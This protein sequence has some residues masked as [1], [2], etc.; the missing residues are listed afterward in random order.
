MT[1]RE[2][3]SHEDRKLFDMIEETP[4]FKKVKGFDV[5]KV[6]MRNA[7]DRLPKNPGNDTYH[8]YLV[9]LKIGT[10]LI[11]LYQSEFGG[12]SEQYIFEILDFQDVYQNRLPYNSFAFCFNAAIK[13][14]VRIEDEAYDESQHEDYDPQD[15]NPD[16]EDFIKV[17]QA[18][19][20]LAEKVKDLREEIFNAQML[21][22]Q[23]NAYNQSARNLMYEI[24][25]LLTSTGSTNTHAE[26]NEKMLKALAIC[27]DVRENLDNA[28]YDDIKP[29]EKIP[30]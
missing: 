7:T 12:G 29:A 16:F 1:P 10:T 15:D 8:E 18:N 11:N 9:T 22:N 2:K 27:L 20:G 30:F 28:S 17:A 24:M 3:M 14:A 21:I 23:K 19:D 13:L 26:R 4:Y 6:P 5:M 25:R